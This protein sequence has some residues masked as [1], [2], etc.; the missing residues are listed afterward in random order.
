MKKIRLPDN[1]NCEICKTFLPA[2]SKVLCVEKTKKHFFCTFDCFDEW[3]TRIM[4]LI[5]H[6]KE[7]KS[8]TPPRICPCCGSKQTLLVGREIPLYECKECGFIFPS[9]IE[10]DK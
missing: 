1:G 10:D 5:G 9:Y 7:A 8:S 2:G 4:K 6:K 3:E